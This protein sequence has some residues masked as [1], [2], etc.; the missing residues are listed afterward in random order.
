MNPPSPIQLAGSSVNVR[1]NA[2]GKV[3]DS[4][5]Q[6]I[7]V[8]IW[9]DVNEAPRARLV[10]AD[11]SPAEGGF[12]ISDTADLIP[13]VALEISLGYSSTAT[14]VFTGLIYQQGICV[15]QNR[16][17]QLVL[18]AAGDRRPVAPP[19]TS[20]EPGLILAYGDSILDFRG[21][22]DSNTM[23]SLARIRGEVRF[24]GSALATAGAT[25]ALAGLGDRYNGPV[26][27]S[28]VHQQV[29][30]GH[31]NTSIK[32]GLREPRTGS[33]GKPD[34]IITRGGLRIAL[35]DDNHAIE[36]STPAKHSVRLDDKTGAV[37]VKDGNGNTITLASGGVTIDS[38]NTITLKA[39]GDIALNA[40]GMLSLNGAAGVNITG[41]AIHASAST[42]FTAQGGAEAKLSSGGVVTVQ[43]ALVKIN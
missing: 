38:T 21:E 20:A 13:G 26:Y 40:Q 39:K 36:I 35:D 3:L 29:S 18:E 5:Y 33:A 11:G 32:I 8:D 34:E 4:S 23:T 41:A 24:R 15:A 19:D 42:S 22:I 16:P 37:T 1:I 7:S 43:G 25:V 14:A 2:G 28:G 27:V 17:S 6:V 10:I 9:S 12:S 31:W 30:E